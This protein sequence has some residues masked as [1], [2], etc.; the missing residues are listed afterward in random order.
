MLLKSIKICCYY[1]ISINEEWNRPMS[2]S[3]NGTS[4]AHKNGQVWGCGF[5]A[6]WCMC[7]VLI[8]N[9]EQNIRLKNLLNYCFISKWWNNGFKTASG[10]LLKKLQVSRNDKLRE[11]NW[12]MKV[13]LEHIL[14]LVNSSI[15]RSARGRSHTHILNN[16]KWWSWNKEGRKYLLQ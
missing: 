14:I 11:G 3:S 16:E 15:T 4:A 13:T 12:Y 2:S 10:P 9:D 1:T 7:N 5:K 6:H 8:K